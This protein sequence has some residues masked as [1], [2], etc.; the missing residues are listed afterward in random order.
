VKQAGSMVAPDR[1]RFDFTHHESIS[2]DKIQEIEQQ[3]NDW[4]MQDETVETYSMDLKEVPN[5]DIVAVFDEKYGDVVR[6]VDIHGYSKELCGGTH[7]SRTGEIGFFRIISE[8]SIASGVR[9]IEAVCGASAFAWTQQEHTLIRN[10]AQRFSVSPDGIVDRIDHLVDQNKALEKE[11]K[12]KSRAAAK[13]QVGS[14]LDLQESLND[15]SLL[16]QVVD[17][18]DMDGLRRIMDGLRS[19]ISSGIIV[20]GSANGGKVQFTASVSDDLV[21]KGYHA[22]KLISETARIAGGGG[23]GQP[24][25]AQAGGKDPSKVGEAIAKVKELIQA[26]V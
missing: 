23:G 18:Q 10:L 4:I 7:V 22:G 6:V 13:D 9:R 16:A 2:H 26:Q 8:S 15:F 21:K 1:L 25:R 19:K 20:L 12:E 14:L 3:V 17:G 5:T 11:L 24:N